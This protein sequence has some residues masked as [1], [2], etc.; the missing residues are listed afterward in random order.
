[1][2]NKDIYVKNFN[3]T[4]KQLLDLSIIVLIKTPD[5]KSFGF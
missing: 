1:M 3:L 4:L 5:L 2:D